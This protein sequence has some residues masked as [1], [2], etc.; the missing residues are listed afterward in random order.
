LPHNALRDPGA[1]VGQAA[2]RRLSPGA[3]IRHNDIEAPTVV[4]KGSMV[5]IVYERP[6]LRLTAPGRAQENAGQ[7]EML[8][9]VNLQS[10]RTV[11]AV[12]QGPNMVAVL[13]PFGLAGLN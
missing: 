13:S 7:N 4:A 10:H 5:T 1:V 12:A 9:V 3:P 6:G 8:S 2:K 11:Q